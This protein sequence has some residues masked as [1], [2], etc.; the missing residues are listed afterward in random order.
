MKVKALFFVAASLIAAGSATYDFGVHGAKIL[1]VSRQDMDESLIPYTT[2]STYLRTGN[3]HTPGFA[4]LFGASDMQK[5]VPAYK[6]NTGFPI[7]NLSNQFWS[8]IDFISE[9]DRSRYGPG[10]RGAFYGQLW[11]RQ[12][13][14]QVPQV[15][16]IYKRQLYEVRCSRRDKDSLLLN[17]APNRSEP[18]PNPNSIVLASCIDQPVSLGP[19]KGAVD[20]SCIR[21]VVIDGFLVTYHFQEQ[22]AGL[23]PQFDSFIGGKIS[24]WKQNCR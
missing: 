13:P 9:R 20:Q 24:E 5:A 16:E 18:M 23:I 22:N 4:V 17:Q 3:G 21:S 10:M 15:L 14:C 8:E 12:V 2:V 1:C 11:N 7:S 6:V 19:Y